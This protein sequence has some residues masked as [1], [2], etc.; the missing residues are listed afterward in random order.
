MRDNET[1]DKV[2]QDRGVPQ[3]ELFV[4][5]TLGMAGLLML[6]GPDVIS[7]VAGLPE[8]APPYVMALGG[9]LV[10]RA[11]GARYLNRRDTP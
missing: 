5:D 1:Q 8:G 2:S 10:A 9:V 7:G 4:S 3:E 6:L 11:A